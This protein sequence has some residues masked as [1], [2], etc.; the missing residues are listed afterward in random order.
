MSAQLSW[1]ALFHEMQA[2]TFFVDCNDLGAE[3]LKTVKHFYFPL[4]SPTSL[5][6]NKPSLTILPSPLRVKR[7]FGPWLG[8]LERARWHNSYP[9]KFDG[10]PLCP[11]T[12][13]C[14]T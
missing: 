2:A 4:A 14:V 7:R 5:G 8:L 12:R 9:A 3:L 6:G 10:G 13:G 11:Y 1:R